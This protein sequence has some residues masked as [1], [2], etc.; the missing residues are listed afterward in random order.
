MSPTIRETY[1]NLYVSATYSPEDNKLRLSC[2][3]RLDKELYLRVKS[4]GFAW[5]PKQEVFVAPKWTPGREDLAIELA[6]EIGDEDTSLVDRAEQRAERFEQYG[7]NR[8]ADAER[9]HKAVHAIADGIPLGQPILVGH[10]SERHARRDAE[11]IENG[12]RRAVKMWDTAKYWEYRAAGAI[13]N[14]KYKERPDVRA[15]RIKTIEAELR[16]AIADFTPV[17]GVRPIM[18]RGWNA[19]PEDPEVPHVWV[20]P[21]GRGGRWVPEAALPRIEA[22]A[23]RW[24]QHYENRLIYERAMLAEGGG[25]KAE[26]FEMEVGGRVQRRGDWFVVVK[27]NKKDDVLLSVSVIG[28]WCATIPVEDVQDYRPPAEGDAEKIK[29]AIAKPPIVNFRKEGCQEMTADQW[30]RHCRASDYNFVDTFKATETTGAYRMRTLSGRGYDKPRIPVFLTDSKEI[31][32]PPVDAKAVAKSDGRYAGGKAIVAEVRKAIEIEPPAVAPESELPQP[33]VNPSPAAANPFEAMRESL[34]AGVKVVSAPQL[35]PTPNALATDMVD[36][37]DIQPGDD[38][39]EP[40]AGT[41]RII[42]AMQPHAGKI[43]RLVA[44]EIDHELYGGLERQYGA[45]ADVRHGDF[46][47]MI[48]EE[49]GGLFDVILMNPPFANADDIKHIMHAKKFLKPGGRLVAICAN[50][51]RQNA[52]LCGEVDTWK[53]LPVGT[54]ES[55]G[56]GVNT[57]MLKYTAPPAPPDESRVLVMPTTTQANLF[58]ILAEEGY[59]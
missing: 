15:R 12:M 27:L 46:L 41:G 52:K 35:F 34:R 31:Q 19:K 22:G 47:E 3:Q 57:A 56:T 24:I 20:G 45:V 54:F 10:H 28:H 4:A 37:A 29:K 48:P 9:A 44:V 59:A 13:A 23:Q 7:E 26:Q 16:S 11:K 18:Q 17:P 1:P 51:P 49:L 30:K 43:G 8:L 50:G 36:E 14:A 39:L 58:D 32:A 40:S 55:S 6:G 21:K 38:V 33:A 42:Y 25:L 2:S 5:A 53:N